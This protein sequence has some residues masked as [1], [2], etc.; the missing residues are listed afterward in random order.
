M[1]APISPGS[2]G[3]PI[4]NGAGEVIGISVL[5]IEGGQN[6]NFA[7]PI[8]YARWM[9]NMTQTQSLA[10]VYEP[11]P[12]VTKDEACPASL[13]EC[14][15]IVIQSVG[16]LTIRDTLMGSMSCALFASEN[17][18]DTLALSLV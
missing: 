7:V 3:G 9:L 17:H 11:E 10:S 18:F 16:L 14:S 8:D 15:V 4:F 5:T 1:S 13:R 12:E 6:L 2:S